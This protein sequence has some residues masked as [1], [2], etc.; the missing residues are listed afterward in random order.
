MLQAVTPLGATL[1]TNDAR[2][3]EVLKYLVEEARG[4][5]LALG[6]V[7]NL[8]RTAGIKKCNI[9]ARPDGVAPLVGELHAGLMHSYIGFV[10]NCRLGP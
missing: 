2:T 7:T 6:D 10:K 4:H 5:A 8:S 3:F 1:R 9:E